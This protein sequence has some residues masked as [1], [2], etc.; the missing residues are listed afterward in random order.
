MSFLLVTSSHLATP[1]SVEKLVLNPFMRNCQT[2]RHR[3]R[4]A[5]R[6]FN[7]LFSIDLSTTLTATENNAKSF[8]DGLMPTLTG[9]A[10]HEEGFSSRG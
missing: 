2:T 5:A 10:V 1:P 7:T 8:G 4:T 9:T 3:K 6:I